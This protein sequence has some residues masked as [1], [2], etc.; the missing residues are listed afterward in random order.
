M[1][2]DVKAYDAFRNWIDTA[3]HE[4]PSGV[5]WGANSAT[6]EEC[7]EMLDGLEEFAAL[8]R[9]LSL[10]D[11]SDYVEG[12]RWHFEHYPHYL[13]RRRHFANY[14][15]YVRTRHGPLHLA[16]PPRPWPGARR[17]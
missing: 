1:G 9:R 10:L 3:V 8:C 2:S 15:S 6:A 14:E 17:L 12:C 11:H 5:L 7:A 16:A 4:L 13:G